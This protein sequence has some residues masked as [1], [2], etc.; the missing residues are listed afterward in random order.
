[1]AVLVKLGASIAVSFLGICAGGFA[2]AAPV[3]T[4]ATATETV[5]P[6]MRI[7]RENG[8]ENVRYGFFNNV[9]GERVARLSI[10]QVTLAYGKQGVFRVAWKPKAVLQD[11]KLQILDAAAWPAASDQ[12]GSTLLDL[13]KNGTLIMRDVVVEQAANPAQRAEAPT[14]ELT[15]A[16]ELVL[17]HAQL[18]SGAQARLVLTLRGPRAGDISLTPFETSLPAGSIPAAA[19]SR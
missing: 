5:R 8:P 14:A 2:Y 18:A 15:P 4:P 9:T 12:L 7:T 1:M 3:A 19:K 16:G 6:T 11:V 13:A 10:G 17:P